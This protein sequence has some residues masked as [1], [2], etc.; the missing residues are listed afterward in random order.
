MTDYEKRGPLLYTRR[1]QS[2]DPEYQDDR[3]AD[4]EENDD[5]E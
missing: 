3:Y 1:K 4:E 2:Y 5:E